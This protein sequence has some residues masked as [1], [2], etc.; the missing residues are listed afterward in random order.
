MQSLPFWFCGVLFDSAVSCP[1]KES[2]STISCPLGSQAQQFP[3]HWGVRLSN[4]LPTEES[5]S[6]ISCPLGSQTPWFPAH[7]GV[8]LLDFLPTWESDS[9]ISCPLGSQTPWFP[10]HRGVRLSNFLPNWE[11]D[12]LISWPPGSQT[13]WFPAHR[14]S[15][16]MFPAHRVVRLH[17]FLPTWESNSMISCPPWSRPPKYPAHSR[18]LQ[19]Y[20]FKFMNPHC[21]AYRGVLKMLITLKKKN[22]KNCVSRL[23]RAQVELLFMQRSAAKALLKKLRGI[24]AASDLILTVLWEEMQARTQVFWG[25]EGGSV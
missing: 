24:L 4:F 15:D 12:S 8:R 16:S 3:A 6:V 14:E 11:S 18:S 9:A 21:S 17:D 7:L 22:E 25:G 10:A 13:P 20:C 19:Y 2:D 23:S 1:S 5:D